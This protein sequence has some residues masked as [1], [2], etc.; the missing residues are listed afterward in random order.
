MG[1]SA[2]VKLY[3]EGS[4]AITDVKEVKATDAFLSLDVNTKHCQTK[5]SL[6]ECTS[7]IYLNKMKEQCQCV[8]F[9]LQNFS[10]ASLVFDYNWIIRMSIKHTFLYL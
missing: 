10:S 2:P 9:T 7:R 8:S 5:E 4:Y 1:Y 6:D 3:G